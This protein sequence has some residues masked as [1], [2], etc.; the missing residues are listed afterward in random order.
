MRKRI[1]MDSLLNK[2][3]FFNSLSGIYGILVLFLGSFSRIQNLVPTP[4]Q[5]TS[6]SKSLLKP[7]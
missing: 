1:S 6:T 7:T 5:E 4:A 2:L 3:F